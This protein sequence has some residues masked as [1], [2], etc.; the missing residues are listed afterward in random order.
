MARY[1][2]YSS[3]IVSEENSVDPK[4][5]GRPYKLVPYKYTGRADLPTRNVPARS[6]DNPLSEKKR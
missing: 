1:K 6:G 3:K 5:V 2:K 4:S